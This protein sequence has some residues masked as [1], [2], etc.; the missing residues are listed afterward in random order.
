MQHYKIQTD[1]FKTL[2]K[3]A[4]IVFHGDRKTALSSGTQ[5][6]FCATLKHFGPL[7]FCGHISFIMKLKKITAIFVFPPPPPN[8]VH[9][10][11]WVYF[12]VN[13]QTI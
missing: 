10:R 7:S 3:Q 8:L 6:A 1:S 2:H 13:P 11:R 5:T 4:T 12:S 9:N